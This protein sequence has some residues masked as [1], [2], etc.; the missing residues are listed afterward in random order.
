MSASWQRF[1][2]FVPFAIAV[3]VGFGLVAGISWPIV[4]G[5]L[6]GGTIVRA[7]LAARGR[8]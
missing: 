5:V 1:V 6:I 8:F 2:Q 4:F 3:N 7:Y